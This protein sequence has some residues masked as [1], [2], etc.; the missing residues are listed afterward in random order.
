VVA[1]LLV[2]GGL[3]GVQ[4]VADS[5]D[6]SPRQAYTPPPESVSSFVVREEKWQGT[7]DVIGSI[8]AVQ[9]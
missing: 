5:G 8:A 1:V 9:G 7:L 3:A 6:D 4:D 2:L